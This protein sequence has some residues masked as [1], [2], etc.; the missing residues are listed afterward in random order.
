VH[1]QVSKILDADMKQERNHERVAG[2]LCL[3]IAKQLAN[4][5]A[6]GST[7]LAIGDPREGIYAV[8]SQFATGWEKAFEELQCEFTPE[9]VQRHYQPPESELIAVEEPIS[10]E[11]DADIAYY[12]D[13]PFPLIL[14]DN[15]GIH[16]RH[17]DWMVGL[18]NGKVLEAI[19]TRERL[20]IKHAKAVGMWTSEPKPL[21]LARLR[22]FNQPHLSWTNRIVIWVRIV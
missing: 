22:G 3:A 18:A 21:A 7:C 20:E 16:S 17:N 5:A 8:P 14:C 13:G 19:D 15:G 1:Q 2:L 12:E 6:D 9:I 4:E 10:P 11:E